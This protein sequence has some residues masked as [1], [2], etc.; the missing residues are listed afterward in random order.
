MA[1]LAMLL[2]AFFAG[3]V[4]GA[5]GLTACLIA[6]AVC[7]AGAFAGDSIARLFSGHELAGFFSLLG[8]LPRMGMPLAFCMVVGYWRGPLFEAGFVQ[9][10]LAFYLVLLALSTWTM[11]RRIANSTTGD[12]DL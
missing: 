5:P 7:I 12:K 9:Y 8:M 1:G 4:G 10:T 6:A 11:T 2:L 3:L